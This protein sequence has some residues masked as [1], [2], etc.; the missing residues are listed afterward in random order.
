[1]YVIIWR[2]QVAEQH[3]ASF[4]RHYDD[5]GEW[6]QLFRRDSAYKGTRLLR[7][8]EDGET[9]ISID[10]WD[11]RIAYEQFLQSHAD[12]YAEMD[13]FCDTLTVEESRIGRFS[14]PV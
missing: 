8:A 6:D 2:Y 3:V 13:R 14:Y 5:T 11:S 7:D 1:M 10:Y 4:L 12:A 9:Y